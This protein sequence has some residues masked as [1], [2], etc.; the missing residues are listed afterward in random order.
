MQR[1]VI[2]RVLSVAALLLVS[3]TATSSA[4]AATYNLQF[5]TSS[6]RTAPVPLDGVTVAGT[7]FAFTAP[8]AG[9]S[10]VAFYLDDQ[11]MSASP[12]RTEGTAPF[13][14]AGGTLSVANAFDTRT[15]SD[16]VHTI[17]AKVTTSGGTEVTTAAFTVSNAAPPPPPPPP[18]P[19]GYALHVSASS[20]RSA[21]ADLA[22]ATR[23]GNVYVFTAPAT[24]TVQVRFYLDDP[25]MS[26][27]PRRT[28]NTG[29]WDFAGGTAAAAIAFD[30][31]TIANGGHS[32]TAAIDTTTGRTSVV[33]S[34]FTVDNAGTPPPPPP[35]P[36]PAGETFSWLTKTSQPAPGTYESNGLGVGSKLYVFGG[37]KDGGLLA[38]TRSDVYDRTT[39]SWTSLADMPELTTHAPAVVDGGTIWLIGGYVGNSPGPSTLHVWKYNI[40]ANSWSPGPALP[41]ARGAGAAAIVGRELHYMGGALRIGRTYSD[42]DKAD[43]WVL[44]LDGGTTWSAAPPVPNPRNHLGAAVIGQTVYVVGGQYKHD[45]GTTAQAQVDAYDTVTDSWQRKADLPLARSHITGSLVV[46][47]GRLLSIGGSKTNGKSGAAINDVTSYDPATDTWV[48]LPPL[49][50]VRKAPI[51]GYDGFAVSVST[52]NQGGGIAPGS[53]WTGV[54]SNIWESAPAAPSALGEVAGGQIGT[55]LYLVGEGSGATQS[56]DMSRRTWSAVSALAQRPYVGHHH[57]AEVIGAKLYLF[58]GLGAG[59]GKVQIYDPATNTWSTGADMPF[60][61]GSSASAMIGGKVYVAGGIVGTSTTAQAAVYDAATNSWAGMPSMKQ[62]RNHTASTTDGTKFYVFG[63]R[64]GG[65]T[66]TNGFDTVQVYDPAA[67]S[68]ASSLDA[69]SAIAPMPQ[70]RGGMGKAVY[71]N[72]EFYVIGGETSTGAGATSAKV[73]TRVDIYRP[74]TAT[75]RAGAPMPT[76]RHG[77]FPLLLNGRIYAALGGIQA[78][79]SSSRVLEVYSID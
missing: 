11:S 10:V 25:A 46:K 79:N 4:G 57:A 36:P 52:G 47:N 3:I 23:S 76:A 56:Y 39:D 2:G 59:A 49:P 5:S 33:T 55:K 9:A 48:A 13:D 61:A 42:T 1:R 29:P 62:G 75:W 31:R 16:G 7:I 74:S 58:G 30:T 35:P 70:L 12:R 45:E 17:T 15:I 72:G 64:D 19:S 54:L 37:F 18:P 63:G 6:S 20:D 53:T 38:T 24:E 41:E 40:A 78:A 32:I 22:G 51:A 71:A 44:P 77:I 67:G 60:A 66:V 28:E 27:A 73:Y 65:N 50:A 8:D 26:G 34:S 21:P 68:W 14:F 69:G 43:H